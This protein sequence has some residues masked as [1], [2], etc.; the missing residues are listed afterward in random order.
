MRKGF[1]K[2]ISTTLTAKQPNPE[3]VEEITSTNTPA[4]SAQTTDTHPEQGY[5]HL[6]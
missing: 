4:Q 1:D 5:K 2:R 3:V 6:A